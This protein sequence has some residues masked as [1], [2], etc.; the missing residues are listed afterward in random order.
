M[1]RGSAA[2]TEANAG[3]CWGFRYPVRTTAGAAVERTPL[4]DPV[5]PAWLSWSFARTMHYLSILITLLLALVFAGCQ[6][7][8]QHPVAT[9]KSVHGW[10]QHRVTLQE[11]EEKLVHKPQ[12]DFVAFSHRNGNRPEAIEYGRSQ[13]DA[14]I[15][16]VKLFLEQVQ[17]NDELW[18]YDVQMGPLSGEGG[19]AIVREGKVVAWYR[20]IRSSMKSAAFL[21]L[22]GV[23]RELVHSGRHCGVRQLTFEE[24]VRWKLS[25]PSD[26][27][28][29]ST[30]R[31]WHDTTA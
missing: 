10:L 26:V 19:Y 29:E 31:W 25:G 18:Y 22:M 9:S 17:E 13:L 14:A 7:Y 24:A 21:W 23:F 11:V 4:G 6:T 12:A 15:Q 28:V 20:L 1:S 8:H 30:Q 5:S 16:R 2:E 3:N 27:E